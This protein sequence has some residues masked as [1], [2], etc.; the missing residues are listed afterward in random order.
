MEKANLEK[1][2]KGRE[3]IDKF[4][5]RNISKETLDE[6]NVLLDTA[7]NELVKLGF[8]SMDE[9]KAFN[10]KMIAEEIKEVLDIKFLGCDKC[11]TKQ[12]VKLFG[13]KACMRKKD[14]TVDDTTA[15]T[16]FYLVH[17]SKYWS[18]DEIKKEPGAVKRYD[19]VI[20]CP[21]GYG[22]QV[23][24]KKRLRQFDLNWRM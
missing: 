4:R 9:F 7:T 16:I 12:C 11:P 5:L 18:V 17:S 15:L 2:L 8:K 1:L 6:K 13:D 3:I 23:T 19:D 14:K 24:A 22:Y 10:K 21:E 20:I